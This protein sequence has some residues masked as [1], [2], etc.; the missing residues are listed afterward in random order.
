MDGISLTRSS[1]EIDDLFSGY[2]VNLNSSTI[3]NGTNTPAILSGTVDTN[4]AKTNLQS[5]VSAIND[6]RT[7]LNDKIFRGS[8]IRKAGDLSDDPVIKSIHSRLN[9]LTSNQLTGFGAN[10]VYLSNLG[11]RTEKNGLLSLNTNVLETE[12]KNN[13]SS[14][15]AIFNPMYS[16]T[17]TLLDVSGASSSLPLQVHTHLR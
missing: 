7:L 9:T 11:V 12:L 13:P 2:K 3:V 17:S 5:F 1:N 6:A 4:A 8:S 16:S 15:D 10:G 14:L